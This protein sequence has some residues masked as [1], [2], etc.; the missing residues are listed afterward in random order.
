MG[1]EKSKEVHKDNVFYKEAFGYL[2]KKHRGVVIDNRETKPPLFKIVNQDNPQF[3]EEIVENGNEDETLKPWMINVIP[4][5]ID[6]EENKAL[7]KYKLKLEYVF[8]F[9][10]EDLRKN[11]FF[12][13]DD[14]LLYTTSTVAVIHTIDE[15]SQVI[16]G[17]SSTKIPLNC[18]NSEIKS[19][20]YYRGEVSIVAT[21]QRG[22]NPLI[23]LWSPIDPRII[24]AKF[25][26]S[27]G[28]KE[29]S[30]IAFDSQGIYIASYGR[31][32]KNSFF[33]FDIQ[34]KSLY[35]EQPTD[36]DIILDIKF[37]PSKKRTQLCI[38]GRKKVLFGNVH[39]KQFKNALLTLNNKY[40][41]MIFTS[42]CY[43]NDSSCIIG[44]YDGILLSFN[45]KE[46][47]TKLD[48]DMNLAKG[49]IEMMY[50]FYKLDLLIISDSLNTLFILSS[51]LSVKEKVKTPSIVQSITL[52]KNGSMAYGMRDGTIT[53]IPNIYEPKSTRTSEVIVKTHN[54]GRLIG[55]DTAGDKYI[56]T[57][58]E[59]NK[60]M[61]WNIKTYQCDQIAYI[62]IVTFIKTGDKKAL[63]SNLNESN[64]S[65]AVSYCEIKDQVSIGICNGCVSIRKG[66]KNLNTKEVSDIKIGEKAVI[67]LKY[68]SN[69]SLLAVCCLSGE[70]AIIDCNN[71]Y[72]I[73][74]KIQL[75]DCY[76][77]TLDWDNSFDFI[78]T[79]TNINTF[80][81]YYTK[82]LTSANNAAQEIGNAEWRSIT[83]KFG[84]TVQ[85]IY[86]G[87]TD[88]EFISCVGKSRHIKLL[89]AGD[90]D[91]KLNLFNYPVI[92]EN[93]KAKS[94][95]GHSDRISK[96]RFSKDDTKIFTIGT[97]DKSIFIWSVIP[98]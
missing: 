17:G 63:I 87:T 39:D 16:F 56:I 24:Y 64:K 42:V 80:N 60:I 55:L 31:D 67:D 12:V 98:E 86:M 97:E 88:P 66:I 69:G 51:D 70:L 38:V 11:L 20:A 15:K 33:V 43:I 62:G 13:S 54:E 29:V 10:T 44:S 45:T 68:T 71:G 76:I 6:L 7:P 57:T 81:Y 74:Q 91:L 2:E 92:T 72:K 65:W 3:K 82:D 37:N 48:R 25:T 89:A 73:K 35:W 53:L 79:V 94:Y 14:K 18:H 85:G 1:N 21:G 50:F 93:S 83:C 23:I 30:G 19:I 32:T 90:D 4:S 34:I 52:S 84:Y 75:S 40:K 96:I 27:R 58:G 59:D 36:E 41:D 8:G 47:E 95:R 46:E 9:R 26:Q 49:A 78:Q 61:L 22:L 28:S 5:S 77:V